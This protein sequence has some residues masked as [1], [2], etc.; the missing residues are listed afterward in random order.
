MRAIPGLLH[1]AIRIA[2]GA[3]GLIA[4]LVFGSMGTVA[5][6]GQVVAKLSGS[7][8]GNEA[9]DAVAFLLVAFFG[10]LAYLLA[11]IDHRLEQKRERAG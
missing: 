2:I 11:S 7:T 10:G 4:F 1:K 9:N 8:F 5:A 6:W 3:V